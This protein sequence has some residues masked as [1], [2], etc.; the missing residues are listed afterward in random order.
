MQVMIKKPW[1]QII[2]YNFSYIICFALIFIRNNHG[3][4]GDGH[5]EG[6]RLVGREGRMLSFVDLC[7]CE[8]YCVKQFCLGLAAEISGIW[9]NRVSFIEHNNFGS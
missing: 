5:G 9:K 3:T 1:F 7:F 8:R 4:V 6:G 2:N